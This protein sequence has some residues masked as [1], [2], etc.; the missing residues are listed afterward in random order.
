MFCEWSQTESLAQSAFSFIFII[1]NTGRAHRFYCVA[2]LFFFC[3]FFRFWFDING[4]V[5]HFLFDVRAM[6]ERYRQIC[7]WWNIYCNTETL[8]GIN[9]CLSMMIKA[10]Y[11]SRYIWI[12]RSDGL[13]T[14]KI[15]SFSFR[16]SFFW[17][18]INMKCMH[19]ATSIHLNYFSFISMN[20]KISCIYVSWWG[21]WRDSNANWHS[22]DIIFNLPII[23]QSMRKNKCKKI[24]SVNGKFE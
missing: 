1:L 16:R 11:I 17:H 15:F 10:N 4:S 20:M 23:A 9:W 14:Q 12:L 8:V 24:D 19:R 21:N 6:C 22:S 7:I 18:S 2:L 13:S 3:F 5:F